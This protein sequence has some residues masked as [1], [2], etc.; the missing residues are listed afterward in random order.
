MTQALS[1]N[2]LVER[3]REYKMSPAERHAQRVSL[4]LGLRS[5]RSTLT[6][7]KV[8]ELMGEAEVPSKQAASAEK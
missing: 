5:E 8:E 1:L 2:E 6:R 7:Q 3:A 4:V